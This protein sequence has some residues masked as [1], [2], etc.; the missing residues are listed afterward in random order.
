[1]TIRIATTSY[2]IK[3]EFALIAQT[4]ITQVLKLTLEEIIHLQLNC[5]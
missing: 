2:G 4:F 3:F 5:K 1:M